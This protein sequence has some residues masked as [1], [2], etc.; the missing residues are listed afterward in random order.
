[1]AEVSDYCGP[2][3]NIHKG[4]CLSTLGKFM[5]DLLGGSYLVLNINPQITGDRPLM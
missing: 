1:M 3:W 2:E 5:K 4:F